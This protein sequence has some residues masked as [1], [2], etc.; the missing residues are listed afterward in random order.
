MNGIHTILNYNILRKMGQSLHSEVFLANKSIQPEHLLVLK[1]IRQKLIRSKKDLHDHLKQQVEHL[2]QLRL[3]KTINP[4]LYIPDESEIFLVCE[5]FDGQNLFDWRKDRN[6]VD[7]NDF[8][9]ISCSIV[10][11]LE[12]IHKAG[13]FHCGIKPNNILINPV[14]LDIQL[15]DL[16]RVIHFKD[17][18]HFIYDDSFR[19]NTLN[20]V[21]PEQTGR[22]K[23]GVD[24]LTDFY[25]LG[26]VFYELLNGQP[27]FASKDPLEIIHSHL[28]EDPPLLH[29]ANPEIPEIISDIVAK[30]IRKEP[31][32]RYQ[33]ARGLL[34]DLLHCQD[35]YLKTGKIRPFNLGL[36]DYINRINIPC[37]MVGRDK[38]KSLLLKEHARSTSGFFRCV[39]ISGLPGIGKTRLIQELQ[40]PI[41]ASKSY[42]TLGKFDQFQKDV[43]YST[44]IQAFSYLI[45]TFLTE[46]SSRIN[47]RCE[48]IRKALGPNGKLIADLVPELELITGSFPKVSPLSPAEA[49]RR[50]N[51]TIE[52]FIFCLA[53]YD[54][55]LTLFIDDLQ[56]CDTASF[57]IIEN[58]FNNYK[59]Y[60]YL[61]LLGAYRHNEVDETHP[62][63][64]I[65]KKVRK[66]DTPLLELRLHELNLNYSN[67]MVAH[68]INTSFLRTDALTKIVF[69]I[70]EGNPLYLN[71]SLSW[72]H[73]KRLINLGEDGVWQW[74]IEQIKK[75]QIPDTIVSLF[76]DKIRRLPIRTV[77]LLQ[78]AACLGASFKALDLSLITG[79]DLD[80]LYQDLSAAFEQRVLIKGTSHLSFFHDRIQEAVDK[81]LDAEKLRD[82]HS[83]IAESYI[84][85]V[86]KGTEL[87]TVDNLFSIVEHL[88]KGRK[89]RPEKAI[90]YR[91]A[92]LNYHAGEKAADALALE[93]ANRFFKECQML[94]P[95][96]SWN[97]DYEFT[98]NVYKSLARS[99]LTRGNQEE[100]EALLNLLLEKSITDLDRAKCLY[101]QTAGFS[102][103][104]YFENAIETANR[105]LALFDKAIPKDDVLVLSK[106]EELI[107]KI[108]K[109]NPDVWKT[110]L[111]MEPTDDRAIQIELA[112]YS[113]LIPDYYLSGMVSQLLLSGIQSTQNCLA[114]GMDESVIY[115]F[116]IMGLYLQQRDNF[117]MSFKY[118]DLAVA[119]SEK[120]PNTFG[121]TRGMN[122]ILWCNMHNRSRPE[123][124]IEICLENIQRGKICGDLYNGGLSYAPLIWNMIAM[125]EDLSK[126]KEYVY[127]CIEF[128]NKYNLSLSSGL[129]E[130]V[131]AGWCDEMNPGR[132]AGSIKD[133][134][135]KIKQWIQDKHVVSIGC[136]Y[137]LKGISLYYLGKY[138]DAVLVFEKAR[139]YL[140]GLTDN[141][142]NRLWFVFYFLTILRCEKRKVS[143]TEVEKLKKELDLCMGKVETWSKQGPILRPYLALMSAEN[144]RFTESP[145]NNFKEAR[146]LYF[147]AA[148][149]AHEHGYILLEGHIHECLG[150]LLAARGQRQARFHIQE[151]ALLYGRCN[152]EQKLILI[153]NNYPQYLISEQWTQALPIQELDTSYLMKAS[154]A[155]SQEL[156]LSKLLIIIMKSVMERQGASS[157]YL[158]METKGELFLRAEGI[159]GNILDVALKNEPLPHTR[160]LSH[161]IV[162]YV[163]RTKKTVILENAMAG[164]SF[165]FDED[166][167]KLK[168]RSVLCL[169][170]MKQR[171]MKGILYLQNNMISSMFTKDQVEFTSLLTSQAAVSMENAILVEELKKVE[172]QSL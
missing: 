110:I 76:T 86:P 70:S 40:L 117:E 161:A 127:E 19:D 131:L 35:E 109:E 81:T 87:E 92:K 102:S 139:S 122:G 137:T 147:D 74:D 60:P 3:P 54:H 57:D 158:F 2:Q 20:Y 21:S 129:A 107:K 123:D 157:G 61:F 42:F 48:D 84:K 103:L 71:E 126:T 142:L 159:K 53:D 106:C 11:I 133:M 149:T 16:V 49:R 132:T 78:I 166:V 10:K 44:L 135:G 17:I 14:T 90:C 27:P 56:W 89:Q 144:V 39:M 25:S 104:G 153:N 140:R 51:R 136:Y 108:H 46:D 168:I 120:Y 155:I 114:G 64:L 29:Q 52:R 118:E 146:N 171:E 100:S 34:L 101:E 156:D 47:H 165:A 23:Q 91:D 18:S 12:G 164:G 125:G 152:A 148:D 62:L 93:V 128:T 99:E 80:I 98:F 9:S 88:N 151:A 97:T 160:G 73:R 115:S 124:I 26:I 43:P 77:K 8:F 67:E 83:Y 55:P 150:E 4:D 32:R 85:A 38:E 24:H 111:E 169:P 36:K 68:I 82:L 75:H 121:A 163:H 5:Y 96:D 37:I 162:R 167:Q 13:H 119:L 66:T 134:E 33:T 94:L 113:E 65:L 154:L 170:I 50:F 58:I 130:A 116:C 172:R 30:L 95:E 28:A 59:D 31:E 6:K 15:I 79:K 22:I 45:V 138:D 63:S 141:I 72:L 105:G 143:T 1:R 145:V 7:L 112:I 41:V 69:S